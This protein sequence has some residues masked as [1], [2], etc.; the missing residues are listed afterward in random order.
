MWEFG[1]VM[2]DFSGVALGDFASNFELPSIE[3]KAPLWPVFI[4]VALLI[5]SIGLA[6]FG[7]SL[8]GVASLAIG[9]LGYLLTPLA[10]A[11]LLIVAMR[12]HR[13]LSAVDGYVADSG[14]KLI[15]LSAVIAVGGFLV[16]VPHIWQIADYFAL[17]FAPGA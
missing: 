5:V 17:L 7:L 16:A 12:S 14:T 1:S 3:R 4:G 2:G 9:L 10:T 6:L 11:A 8:E 13:Q 15:R